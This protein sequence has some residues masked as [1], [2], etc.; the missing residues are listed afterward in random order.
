MSAYCDAILLSFVLMP[1]AIQADGPLLDVRHI[2]K[3]R[4]SFVKIAIAW[5]VHIQIH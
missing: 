4:G 2:R 1:P 3:P 5:D